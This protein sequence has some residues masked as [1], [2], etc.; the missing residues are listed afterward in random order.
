VL[1]LEGETVDEGANVNHLRLLRGGNAALTAGT[2]LVV[3][4]FLVGAGAA[5]S[6]G[7]ASSSTL[8]H[9]RPVPLVPATS[10]SRA[11]AAS[12]AGLGYD[13]PSSVHP[14]EGAVVNTT[15]GE[16]FASDRLLVRFRAGVTQAR[17]TQARQSADA[18]LLRSYHLVPRLEL[19]KVRSGQAFTAAA[20]LSRKANVAYAVPDVV[21]HVQ[22]T[23]DDPLYGQQW[24]MPSVGAPS[25]WD[26][27]TGSPSVAVAVL[28]TG[29]DATHPD[30][31][32]NLLPGWNFV[33]NT[34]NT[35][36]G[37]GHGT[38]V[39]GIIGATGNN[40]IGV[41]GVNWSVSLMPL[42]VCDD[43]GSCSLDAEIS[44]LQ[45]AVDHGAKV[46]NASFG[47]F[48]GSYQP[49][50][51]AIQAAGNAGLLY[52]AAAGNGSN[53][54]DTSP[55]FPASYPLANII[56]VAATTSDDEL[57]SFSDYGTGSVDIA[58]PGQNILSTLPT[59]G[60]VI[61]DPSG[62]GSLS[63]TSMAAPYVAG[64]AALL[65]SEH[66]DW[67]MQQVR[68][69][70]LS[71]ARPLNS[72]AG[73][74]AGCGELNLDSATDPTVPDQAQ[75]CVTRSG[76]GSGS[77][78]SSPAGI[79]C[80]ATCVTT[81]TPGTST[82]LTASPAAGST[83]TGWSG[84][85]TGT[86]ACTVSPTA[87]AD[88]IATFR[89]SG[90]PTGWTEGLL[91]PPAGA[92]PLPNG[93]DVTTS[94]YNVSLSGDGSE[95]AET[96]YHSPPPR[97]VC[98][99]ATTDTG[100]VYLQ[101]KTNSGWV[102]DATLTAP[103]VGTDGGARWANCAGFGSV[104]ELSRDGSTLLVSQSMAP[105]SSELGL[106][107]RC[108]AF[109]YKRGESG[110]TLDG[111]L[112]PPGIDATGSADSSG[113]DYFGIGGAISDDGSRI[114]VLAAG[115][116]DVYARTDSGWQL[117]QQLTLPTGTECG[118]SIEPRQIALS[119]DGAT[120]LLSDPGCDESGYQAVGRVYAY[121]RSGSIWTLAQTI[122]SPEPQLQNEFGFSLAISPDG[123]TAAISESQATGLPLFAGATWIYEHT[124]TGWQPQ[125]RLTALA[126][127]A[128]TS[129]MCPD[130][131]A[132]GERIVCGAFDTVGFDA[133]QGSLY[134]F[135]R[136]A[137]GWA[138][139]APS[140]ARAFAE[141]GFAYDD[142][143]S[144]G[145]Y[146][147]SGNGSLIDATIQP[148]NIASGSYPHDR[149]GY[150][151]TLPG[152]DSNST[153]DC[154]QGPDAACTHAVGDTGVTATIT[155]ENATGQPLAGKRVE[156]DQALASGGAS[157]A[158]VG[159][160]PA[161]A[162]NTNVG[163]TDSNG[164]V[165]VA[166]SDHK[167][168]AVVLTATDL[169]DW[170]T[171][172]QTA[173]VSYTPG[174]A[175]QLA[176]TSGSGA[177]KVGST[178]VLSAE[179]ED[180]YG[181]VRSSD[182]STVLAFAQTGG[183]GS[184]SNLGTAT[185]LAGIATRTVTGQTGGSV[186]V[187]ASAPGVTAATSSF[188]VLA[189]DGSGSMSVSPTAVTAGSTGHTLTFTYAVASGGISGGALT[190]LVPSGWSAP[191]LTSTAAGYTT[192]RKGGLSVSGQT[193]TISGLTL[194]SGQK[195]TV[196]YGSKGGG[197]PGVTAPATTRVAVQT[198]T[199][200]ERSDLGGR[201]SLL[202]S[203]PQV[204]VLD[205]VVVSRS[206]KGRGKVTSSPGSISC[207]KTCSHDYAPGT[208]VIL[209]AKAAK[210]SRFVRWTGACK[211]SGK[212]A[213]TMSSNVRVNAKFVLE[214]CVVPNVV[215]KSLRAARAA[216]K[217]AYCSVGKII[218]D[219]SSSVSAGRVISERP[220]FGKRLKQ[221]A[222]V[223]LVVSGRPAGARPESR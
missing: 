112:F 180:A 96:V 37:Y 77:V 135:D 133:A 65:W 10:G 126:P 200:K 81:V 74:V 43:S 220:K 205:K 94:F 6:P 216:L 209:K 143:G 53:N 33:D 29:I 203:S 197:G 41:T 83:F 189:P 149:I 152:V 218:A 174:A 150:D 110:W 194:G 175:S 161:G 217:K 32:A 34:S 163:T 106:R 30:L 63:G 198:W 183:T 151:F 202:A 184:L 35:S 156:L 107:W 103:A 45:Y 13:S 2:V 176:F 169:T 120:L 206:G 38:H 25:A 215:G 118:T 154:G 186:T 139:G 182:N 21:L 177:I 137:A 193:I 62:Y 116:A 26:R 123:S 92:D 4:G 141:E 211:G 153:L 97:T 47:G 144:L 171:L 124:P 7:R 125:T 134:V 213:I 142:L 42:K 119:G 131:V 57:A 108:A 179:V 140:P 109:V 160:G 5:A 50:E 70:L 129:F 9:S 148:T 95:R 78:T 20:V 187:T 79:D 84:A 223:D 14:V 69:R 127:E 93:S 16:T 31:T 157:H 101:H 100:G 19:L 87:A 28:D 15:S 46:A 162:N 23:P 51:D 56:S 121:T 60:A 91:P 90:T 73:K 114:A 40:G 76:T 82:T 155:I 71:T 54:N 204:R 44:A 88:V 136:P 39:A 8:A 61:S 172:S 66:P 68:N 188:Q 190:L 55:F 48:Y 104:T 168:E 98:Y 27:T 147:V 166:V 181:N 113:C 11:P 207:G 130:I 36:D 72:L 49:E 117:E 122:D 191:S 195:V 85:C 159:S 58:A 201:L 24:G 170:V 138:S 222:K 185:A 196:A 173:T 102:D 75:L 167:A 105:V 219:A 67:T 199:T 64:A 128:R 86:G 145:Q 3:A 192:T 99:Y 208:L 158:S 212:C 164:Q 146:G 22:S 89:T 18:S 214:P 178:K 210:G 52:V 221:H 59:A 1:T 111:T 17:E 12:P 132:D 80:G 115:T 165:T